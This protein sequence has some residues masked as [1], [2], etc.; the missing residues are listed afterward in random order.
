MQVTVQRKWTT[1]LVLWGAIVACG[2]VG[3]EED[4]CGDRVD[5]ALFRTTSWSDLHRWIKAFPACDDGYFAEAISEYVTVFLS[6]DWHSLPKLE[7]EIRKDANFR[8]VV[9]SHIDPTADP[10]NLRAI[11]ENASQRCPRQSANLCKSIAKAAHD[12]LVEAGALDGGSSGDVGPRVDGSGPNNAVDPT[13]GPVTGLAQGARPAPVPPAG[14]R[15][16]CLHEEER[17]GR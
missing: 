12:A 7:R 15:L 9:L 6:K 3:A 1:T 13:V 10:D 11:A 17:A 4:R 5:A 14:H 16:R 2:D 8:E